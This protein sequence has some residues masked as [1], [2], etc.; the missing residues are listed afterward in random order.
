MALGAHTLCPVAIKVHGVIHATASVV[1]AACV[2]VCMCWYMKSTTSLSLTLEPYLLPLDSSSLLFGV[3]V[4][5]CKQRLNG[6]VDAD[7]LFVIV[8][9]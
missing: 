7:G 5:V 9:R 2:R 4:C 6:S 1:L 3:C 8:D